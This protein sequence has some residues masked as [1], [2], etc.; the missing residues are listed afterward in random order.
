VVVIQRFVELHL[1]LVLFLLSLLGPLDVCVEVCQLFL[2]PALDLNDICLC[3]FNELLLRCDLLRKSFLRCL[4]FVDN[5]LVVFDLLV[6]LED[7]LVKLH[8]FLLDLNVL[9]F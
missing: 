5:S 3:E 6:E 9:C 4:L 2:V 1:Q 7:L 8:L